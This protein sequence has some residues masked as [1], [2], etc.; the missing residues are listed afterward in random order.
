VI[1]G[2]VTDVLSRDYTSI[3]QARSDGNNARVWG[4][5]HYPSTVVVG[6]QLGENVANY[7]IQNAMQPLNVDQ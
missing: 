3:S 1:A 2:V 6:N 7:I 5:M 4:G